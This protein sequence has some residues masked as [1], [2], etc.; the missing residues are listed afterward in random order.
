[1]QTNTNPLQKKARQVFYLKR[2]VK[3]SFLLLGISISLSFLTRYSYP[4]F[5]RT[6]QL[7]MFQLLFI[8]MCILSSTFYY[9]HLRDLYHIETFLDLNENEQSIPLTY[10]KKSYLV[11]TTSCLILA[12]IFQWFDLSASI[13][14]FRT[15]SDIFGSLFVVC[16]GYYLWYSFKKAP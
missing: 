14:L 12:M 13:N 1:M 7:M 10:K 5:E 6:E 3:L 2:I 4:S 8:L 9:A 16:F 11:H 15:I